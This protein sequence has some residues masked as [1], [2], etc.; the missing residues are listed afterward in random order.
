[1]AA[2]SEEFDL[3]I[4]GAGPAGAT[5]ALIAA[6]AE[7]S[8]ALIAC[9]NDAGTGESRDWI[10]PSGVAL[11]NDLGI[12]IEKL[13]PAPFTGTRLFSAD[14]KRTCM[15]EDADLTGFILDPRGIS[16]QLIQSATA[17]KR[18]RQ[19]SSPPVQIEQHERSRTVRL[20]DGLSL[21][22]RVL[23][24]ADD[25]QSTASALA[26]LPT[27]A[28]PA[29]RT[30]SA[31]TESGGSNPGLAIV[32]GSGEQPAATIL[33]DRK[34]TQLH[35]PMREVGA[36]TG[37]V[38]QEFWKAACDAGLVRGAAPTT[39][40]LRP[41]LAGAAL[42]RDTHVGKGC[43]LAGAAGGFAAAFSNEELYPAMQS[44]RLAAD[45]AI[46]AF[47]ATVMQDELATFSTAWRGDFAEYLRMPNTDLNLLLPLVFGNPQMSRRVARAFLL[48]Q[49]F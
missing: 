4:V 46:R 47:G 27:M 42:D 1:M 48:G 12:S 9:S 28:T 45:V 37:A 32:L 17:T 29:L 34:W 10:G 13:R 24:V 30:L 36:D 43:L 49:K 41:F 3:A 21:C 8:V 7:R 18:V 23:I 15:V 40:D 22:A 38:L 20:A 25:A 44:G 19:F 5:A 35:I 14:F 6:R 26:G 2:M 39:I 31:A 16:R 11:L 33:Q